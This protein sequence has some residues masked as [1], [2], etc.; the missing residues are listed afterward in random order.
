MYPILAVILYKTGFGKTSNFSMSRGGLV[1]VWGWASE[2][3]WLGLFVDTTCNPHNTW[4][5]TY[6]GN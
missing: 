2:G 6:V 3:G 5:S 4:Q 1:E